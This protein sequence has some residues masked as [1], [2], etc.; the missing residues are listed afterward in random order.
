M[1]YAGLLKQGETELRE[2]GIRDAKTDA[3]LLLN[4][5]SGKDRTFLSVHGDTEVEGDII[6]NY[7]NYIDRRKAHI[8]LQYITGETEFMGLRFEVDENVLIPRVDTEFLT[9]EAL[10]VT[11]DGAEVL[12]LCTGSG[13]I[14]LSVMCYKNNISGTGSDLSDAALKVAERNAERLAEQGRLRGTVRFC[15]S[16]LFER[17]SGTFDVLISNPP[18]IRTAV[19]EELEEEVRDHEPRM[20]LDG[21]EDGLAFYRAIA[22]EAYRYLAGEGRI[23]LEIGYDQGEAVRRIFE[24]KG[25]RDVR[26]KKDY[27][28]NER[29]LSCLNR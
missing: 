12:D 18:Y 11:D 15:K 25:Y 4:F 29:V 22:G 16:D 14:L 21:L 3:Y 8:P 9:E 23:L 2:A 5:L 1:T 19:I 6:E 28:G 27:A 24:E 13:C 20:A 7:V 26:I 10:I 17:I